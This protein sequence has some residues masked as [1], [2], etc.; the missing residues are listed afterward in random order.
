MILIA[1]DPGLDLGYSV[2][3]ADDYNISTICKALLQHGCSRRGR[4]ETEAGRIKRVVGLCRNLREIHE[5]HGL[6]VIS[7]SQYYFPGM[8]NVKS[9]ARLQETV[10]MMKA[11][12]AGIPF[13]TISPNT[14]QGALLSKCPGKTTKDKSLYRAEQLTGMGFKNH[15]ETDAI[16]IGIYALDHLGW[17]K[18]LKEAGINA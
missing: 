7:E 8:K 3:N 11:A 2:W 16:L 1:I 15:N 9:I 12:F 14:W 10:G 5:H 6:R 17:A 13:E 4:P 18:K